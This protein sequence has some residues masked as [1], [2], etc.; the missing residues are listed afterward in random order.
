MEQININGMDEKLQSVEVWINVTGY[1]V[2][3]NDFVDDQIKFIP[4]HHLI[5]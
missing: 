1:V 5:L 3:N 4:K 2:R